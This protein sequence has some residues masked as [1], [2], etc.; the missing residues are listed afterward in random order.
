MT[1]LLIL[2]FDVKNGGGMQVRGA[3]YGKAYGA[4]KAFSTRRLLIYLFGLLPQ[5]VNPEGSLYCNLW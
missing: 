2:R 3:S 5:F 1:K 4:R